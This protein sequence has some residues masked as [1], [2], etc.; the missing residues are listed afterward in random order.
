MH[1]SPPPNPVVMLS[2]AALA[3][4]LPFLVTCLLVQ[5]LRNCSHCRH[6]WLSWPVLAGVFPWYFAT[7]SLKLIPTDLSLVQIK[8]VC[9]VFTLC[10]IAL[11]FALTKASTL[12]RQILAGALVVSIALAV[13]AC[14]LIAA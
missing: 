14:A 8:A 13:I 12:W 2:L 10:L 6:E 11:A 4:E 3:V 5:L 7:F 9:G 1:R